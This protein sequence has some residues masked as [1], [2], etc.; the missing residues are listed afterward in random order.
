MP[1]LPSAVRPPRSAPRG[2]KWRYP[3]CVLSRSPPASAASAAPMA[4]GAVG[5]A[6]AGFPKG[7]L[8]GAATAAHQVEG[9]NTASDLWLAEHVKP[10]MFAEPSGDAVNSFE[11]WPVD[12]DLVRSLGLNT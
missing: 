11:L 9:N 12:L 10:T 3:K 6:P 7:F 5:A 4:A 2:H 8:W 1:L